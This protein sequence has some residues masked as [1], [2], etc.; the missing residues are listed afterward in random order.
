MQK[1]IQFRDSVLAVLLYEALSLLQ[2]S[3]NGRPGPPLSKVSIL[4]TLSTC[5]VPESYITLTLSLSYVCLV[6]TTLVKL[7][8]RLQSSWYVTQC[9]FTVTCSTEALKQYFQKTLFSTSKKLSIFSIMLM[10]NDNLHTQSQEPQISHQIDFSGKFQKENNSIRIPRESR[11]VQ[12]CIYCRLEVL[13]PVLQE[14]WS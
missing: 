13:T 7:K 11:T 1:L 10:A 3:V 8:E 6:S 12:L 4:V 14:I 5:R 9:S 2:I